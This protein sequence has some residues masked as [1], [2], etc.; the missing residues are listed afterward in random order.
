[1]KLPANSLILIGLALRTFSTTVSVCAFPVP[2]VHEA[3]ATRSPL[4]AAGPEVT[5]NVALKVAPAASSATLAGPPVATAFQPAGRVIFRLTF[6]T[7]VG[8]VLTN[9]TTE[10][11]E[12]PGE[13]VCRPG[14]LAPADA[15]ARARRC[16]PYFA[17]TTLACTFWSMSLVGKVFGAV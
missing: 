4:K 11:S 17:A 2:S 13:K 7:G 16:A 9:V 10:S 14:G 3:L 15:G 1:M 12:E 6:L 8:E 5:L